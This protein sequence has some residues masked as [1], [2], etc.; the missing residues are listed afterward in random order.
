MSRSSR[1]LASLL[2][3]SP[4]ST[5]T[6]PELRSPNGE[7]PALPG[8]EIGRYCVLATTHLSIATA[9]LLD[10]WTNGHAHE[11]PIIVARNAR[12]WF[13]ATPQAD[14]A[15]EFSLPNDL[16]EAI[17]LAR[18][19]GIGLLHFDCDGPVLAELPVHDG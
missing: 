18:S 13:V 16:L 11:A 5:G 6:H 2:S 3:A 8:S 12:G 15:R 4:S 19:R 10:S 17:R 7:L 9:A 14:P 1:G